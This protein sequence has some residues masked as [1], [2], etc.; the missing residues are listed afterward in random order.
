LSSLALWR[1]YWPETDPEESDPD[2]FRSKFK[3]QLDSIEA[4][5]YALEDVI[6][7]NLARIVRILHEREDS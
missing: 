6:V 3:S 1:S 7:T 2:E 5:F 4:E